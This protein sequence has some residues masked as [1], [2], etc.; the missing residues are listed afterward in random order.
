MTDDGTIELKTPSNRG[1]DLTSTCNTTMIKGEG[2]P[3]LGDL[4]QK[5]ADGNNTQLGD[6]GPVIGIA[7]DVSI[8]YIKRFLNI[9]HTI[10]TLPSSSIRIAHGIWVSSAKV[11]NS[12]LLKWSSS[13]MAANLS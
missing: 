11:S 5:D 7:G 1:N 9:L 2:V 4:F 13:R 12:L 3:Q 6:C 10:F 8:Y